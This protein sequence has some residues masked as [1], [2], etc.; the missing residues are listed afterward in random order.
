MNLNGEKLYMKV[1]D[2]YEIYSFA[3]HTF[4]I[5]VICHLHIQIFD[6]MFRSNK[7]NNFDSLDNTF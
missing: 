7:P 5:E 4:F 2:L 3:I 1:V 6:A